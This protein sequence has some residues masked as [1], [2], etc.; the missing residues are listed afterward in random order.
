MYRNR[1]DK[2][3]AASIDGERAAQNFE[4]IFTKRFKVR[5]RK[6]TERQD[7]EDHIDYFMEI[8]AK[9][10][11]HKATVDVKS[12]KHSQDYVYIEFVSYGKLGWLYGKAD[13]IGFESPDM[14]S[15]MMVKRT[16]LIDL[17][18]R[19]CICYFTRDRELF[20]YNLYIRVRPDD[21]TYDCTTRVLRTDLDQ[22]EH[23]VLE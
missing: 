1:H 22:L 13:Y 9:D 18:C 7:K 12:W 21:D 5:P 11:V 4:R 3:G 15:F 8:P 2:T 20:D 6:A 10:G 23:W 14:Q 19:K 17:V 16:D